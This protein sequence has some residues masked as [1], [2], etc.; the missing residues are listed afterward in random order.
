MNV[1]NLNGLKF[2]SKKLTIAEGMFLLLLLSY[3]I[4]F[5][6]GTITVAVENSGLITIANSIFKQNISDKNQFIFLKYAIKSFLCFLPYL[7]AAYFAGTSAFGCIIVPLI[8]VFK[9]IF[10]G[11]LVSYIYSVYNIIGIGYTALIIAPYLVFSAFVLL[12]ACRESLCYSDRILKITIARNNT[13]NL[14]NDYK[15]YSLRYLFIL[16][17]SLILA[18]FDSALVAIFFRYFSF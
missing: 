6:I 9:G 13:A 7:C 3:A 17:L 5:L 16:A 4:G 18:L 1:L 12:L 8:T 11:L 2:K 14:F 15:L 10:N